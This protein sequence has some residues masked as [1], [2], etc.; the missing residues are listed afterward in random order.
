MTQKGDKQ[1]SYVLAQTE[2]NALGNTRLLIN[3]QTE[4]LKFHP[5][6]KCRQYFV[7]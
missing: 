4:K 6:F 1:V 3:F 2:V 7:N 5:F